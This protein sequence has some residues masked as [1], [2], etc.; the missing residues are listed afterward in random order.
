MG[1]ILWVILGALAGWIA[2]LIVKTDDEQGFLADVVLGILGAVVGGFVFN[3]FGASGVNGFNLYSLLVAV[4]GAVIV[5]F[6]G[7]A[8]LGSRAA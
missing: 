5:V 7:R 8:L 6:I 1:I 4:V 3:L 2:S